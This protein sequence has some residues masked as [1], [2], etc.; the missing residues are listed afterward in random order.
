MRSNPKELLKSHS[1]LIHS[2][3]QKVISHVQRPAEDWIQH[4]VMLEG[5]DVPFKFKRKK[6]YKS[7][8]GNRVNVTY[9]PTTETVAETDLD[10]MNVVRIKLS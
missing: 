10:V 2:E 5:C 3:M 9:Y 7:L 1:E 6:R 4:T 8:K